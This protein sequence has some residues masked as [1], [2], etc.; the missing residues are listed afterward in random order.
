MASRT[1]TAPPSSDLSGVA[2]EVR[3]Q[4]ASANDAQVAS[5]VSQHH[6]S[7]LSN[8][9][10]PGQVEGEIAAEN[11]DGTGSGIANTSDIKPAS[12]AQN[13][14]GSTTSSGAPEDQPG[15]APEQTS[16]GPDLISHN[17]LTPNLDSKI[18][19]PDIQLAQ[20]V[21]L[22]AAPASQGE[23][24]SSTGEETQTPEV[25]LNDPP[26]VVVPI[27][28]QSTD[29]DAGF[30]FTVPPASFIDVDAGDTLT[31]SATLADG[32]PLPSWLSFDPAT[33]T[34]SGTPLNDDVGALSIRVTATDTAGA[35]AF[36]DFT[37]TV[38]NTNDAPTASVAI[39]NQSTDEDAGFNF[40]VPATSFSDVDV[41]DSLTLSA[42]L[43]DGSSLPSWLSFDPATQTFTGT[44]LNEDVG[45][46][47]VRVT[48]T[49]TAGAT[50]YQDFNVTIANTNDAPVAS[51]AIADQS[52]DEDAG[53]SF[54]VPPASFTDVDVGD[55]LT[56][57]ATL[58][59]GSALP[60]WLSFDPSTQTFTGTPLNEDVGGLN[61]RVTATDTSGASASQDFTVTV[62]NVNDAPVASVTIADQS[63]DE[64]AGFSFTLPASSFTDVDVGDSLT[65]AASLAD[66]SPL[67][68]WLSFDPA[69]QTFS[70]TPL[71]EDV[72][73]LSIRVIATDTA[74]ANASQD[75]T[76]TVNNTNDAPVITSSGAA[77]F[78]ENAT[79]TV[80]T[81]TATDVDVGTTLA[82]SISGA[83]AALFD[84]DATTGVVTFKSSPN[85]EAPADA[86][87]DNVY[88][89]TVGASDGIVTT[90]KDV[91]IS[92]S[93]VNE[94][95]T[96][97][98]G[99]AVSFAER[100]TGAVYT[101][102]ATD[103]DAGATLTYSLTGTDAARFNINATTGVITFK[104]TPNYEAPADAGKNNVYDV[105][106]RASDGTNITTKDV[107]ITVTNVNEAPVI[108]SAATASFAENG[109]GT[110][111]T[112]AAT[113]VDAGTT[114]TYSLAGTDASK[115][116]IDATTGAVTFKTS[117]NYEAP[118]DSGKNNVYNVTVRASDGAL[119]TSKAVAITVTNVGGED[120]V[121]TSA[122][123]AN[124]AENGAGTVY[125]AAAIPEAGKTLTYAISGADASLFDI[126]ATTG[127]VTFK[128]SPNYEAPADA[129][130]NNVYDL[131]ITASDGTNSATKAVAI[132]VTNVNEAP[133]ITSA[134]TASFAENASGAVYTVA[135]TDQDAGATLTYSLTGTD[136]ARFN[137]N[138]TTGEITFKSTP[139][140]EAPA[141]S[142]KN[143][144]YDVTVRASDGVNTTSKAVAISVANVNE[145][146]TITSAAT[147][148]F[149]ENGTGTVYTATATDPDAGTTLS[150]SISG[151]DATLFDINATTGVVTF[152]SA[153]NYEA[154]A[155]AGGNNVYNIAVGASDGTNTT[156]KAV[157]ITVTNVNEAPTITSG[158][159]ASFAENASGTVYTVAA[160]DQDAGATLTY[161]L[162]GTDAARFNINSSTGA[163]TFKS[164]PN[165]EAP[166]DAG[167]N[168]VYDVTV[169][170]SDGTNITSKA[171]AITVT[172][173][174]EA[175]T[176]TSAATASFAENGTGTVYT[177]AATDPDAGTTLTYSLTGADASLFNIDA[178]TGVV[179]F[180]SAPNYETPTDAGANN[181]YN[182][183]VGAS[184]G[185]VT[186]SKAVAVTV[187][188]DANEAPEFTSGGDASFAENASGTVYTAT[189]IPEAG[190]S[191][192]YS[193]TG[194]DA[195]LFNI[196]ATT[197]AVTFKSS[198]NYEAP[199]D[200]GGNNVYDVTVTASDGTLSSTK[201]VAITVSNV[202]EAPTITS[203]ATASFAENGSGTV[204]TAAASDPDAGATLTYSISGAD[205]SL[206]N[207]D[208]TTGVVT[209]KSSPNFEAPGDAGGNNVYDVKVT[210]SDGT[211]SSSKDVAITVV[212]ANDAP[213]ASAVIANQ[214]I[215]EDA[216]FSFAVPASSFAD[217]D[218]GD[219]LTL[220][221]T[222]ADG[223]PLPAW[224]SFNPAT[225]TFSGT[226]LNDDV[227]SLSIRVT[228]TDTSGASATQDFQ[229]T[230]NNTNDGPVASATI[231]GQSAN[232]DAGFSFS[233]APGS[234][235]DVDAGDSLTY[236]ASLA[237]G[238]PLPAWL[239]FNPA[240]QTFSG[241]P[242]NDDVGSLNVRVTATDTAG[243]SAAQ[244]FTVTVNNTNDGPV[245]SATIADQSINEDAGFSFAVPASSFTDVDVGDSLTLS[246]T[247]ADGSP[248][249]AW[250][251][252]NPATQTFSGTP[253]NDDVGAINIRVT[254]TDTSGASAT[255][256]FQV[257]VN[258]TNDAPVI[259]SSGAA[260][261]AENAA[262]TVYTAAATDV[263]AGE[264]LTYS[265]SGADAALFN[266]DATTG[267]V[268]F[269]SSPNYEAPGDA[270]GNNVYD[271]TVG[272]SDGTVTTT[273]DVAISV[274]NVNEGPVFTSATTASFAETASGAAY[275]AAATDPDA[276]AVLTY[277]ISGADAA[278]FDID[279]ATGAVTFKS[280][281]NYEAPGDAGGN[282]VYDVNVTVSDGTNTATQ[283]VAISVT[284]TDEAPIFT[285]GKAASFAEN[286]SGTV[287]TAAATDPD[288][289][290]TITYSIAGADAALFD[291]N[292]TTGAITFKSSPNYE[293]PGDAGGDNVY[294]VIV[295]ATDGVNVT[296][297]AVAITVTNV[298]EAPT[299]TSAAT[300]NFAENGSGTVYTAA[301]TDP[302]AGATLTYSISGADAALFNINATTG[303][304]TFKSSPNYEAP[305]D[306]GGNNIYDVNVTASDGANSA[307]KAVA[308]T[309]TN[310]NEAPTV[311]SA[312]TASFAENGTG[313]VYTA[314]ATDPDAGATLTYS[315]SG[316]DAALFDIDATTGAVTFK[317]SPNY[318][319]PGDTG[320]NNVYD[321]NVTASDGSLSSTKAVAITVTNVNEAPT[322][323]SAATANFAE[324]GSGTVYSAS[325]TDPDAGAS[326]TYSISG[327]DAS[328]FNINATTGAVTFK[329]SPNYEAPTDA[330]GNNVYD[331]KV[332]ASDG[333]LSSTKDVAISVTNVNEAPTL[334]SSAAASFAENGSGTV[335][336][337][338]ATDPDAG[339]TI[340]Y[341][342]SGTDAS[343]FNINATTGAVTFK[344]SPNY[345]APGDTGGNN[346]YDVNV[347]AS[348]GTNSTT[349][350]VAITVTNVNE[351][352]TVTSAATASFAENAAGTV[353]TAAATD[354]DAG[355]SLTYSISGADAA[356]FNINATTGVVTFKSSPDY[357]APGDAGG[358]N[359]Y[360]ITVG[361]SDGTITTTKDVAITVTNVNEGPTLTSAST[362]NFAE[363]A[364]GTVYTASA[365]DP[366]A[367][368][369]LTYSISGA[370]A[371]LFNINATTGAVTFKSSPNYEAPGDAGGN[372]V[373]DVNVTASDGTN[374]A[375]KAVAITVTDVNEGPTV[376]S[377]ATA[378]F[379]EN[380]S[381]TVYTAT[382]TDPDAGA[383][384]TYS[385]SGADAALFNI[386]ATTG[387]VTFK[388]SPNYEAPG[389][390]G[391]NNV[392]DVNVTASDGTNSATKAVAI[393]VTNVNE[394]PTI[395]SAAT[396]SFAENATGTVYTAAATDPDAGATLTYSLTG[397][398]ASLFN[399]NATTGVVTFKSA[400]NYEAPGDAGGNNVYNITVGA[401]DG[402]NTATKAVA[403][404]VTNVNEAPTVTSAA[405]ASFAENGTGTVYT[406]AATDPDAGTTLTYSLTGAD[407]SLFN[408][409]S[410]TG[411]VTF[412]SAPN[413][414]AP[415]DAGGNN[416]YDITVGAS[417]GTNSTTKDVA[418]TVTNVNEAPTG[419][420]V[421]G[422]LSVQETV[423]SGGNI[424]TAYDP[425]TVQPVVA[426]LTASDPEGDSV[427][428]SLVGA[429]AGLFTISGNDIKVASGAFFDY[430][431]TPSYD[432]T[433][434]ATDSGGQAFDQ[435]V[436]VNIANY[437]GTYT[438]TNGKNTANGTSEEDTISGGGGNDTLNGG[439]GN[440]LLEGGTGSDAL[441]GGNG[442]DT[443]TYANATAGVVLSFSA[444]DGN[445]IGSQYANLAAGGISGEASGDS[446]S[447][448]EAFIG[449]NFADTVGGGSTDMTFMLG[450]GNDIFDTNAA[451]NVADV[452]YGGDGNDTMWTGGG[453]DSLYGGAGND[454]LNGEAGIDTAF[455]S[456]AT[457][458][459]TVSLATGGAQN[460]GG[461]GTDTLNSIEN[462]YGSGFADTLTGSSGDNTLW[463]DAGNDTISGGAGNDTLWGGAGNDTLNG[464]TGADLFMIQAGL[465]ID[466]VTGGAGG[467]WID[468][469]ALVDS[470]GNSY[471]GAFPTDWTLMLTSGSITSTGSESLTLSNDSSGYIQHSDGTQVN[472]TEIEQIRW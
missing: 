146:P 39:A 56:Y 356:L 332:T 283:A 303:A 163:I 73:A 29:E 20:G 336:T 185:T 140:Y 11:L 380:A 95:P 38:A 66:G 384:L 264:T 148:S 412:K 195:A 302:D 309:V 315:I 325:A 219:S 91:A 25:D 3:R 428:Y 109:I 134:A 471:S 86:G 129:G 331:V 379:A 236:S 101:V 405:T 19:T 184:D 248:L 45:A 388:S 240:T 257:T 149:T 374:S 186:T 150:Y 414:E 70:G 249:P 153:P 288:A 47:S 1:A 238:S 337:A 84:I 392:Y 67:P 96:I 57:S 123:T 137:I 344:S 359:V 411:V 328:L 263:D 455:Y 401:S 117:P 268:T 26:V 391:G 16:T 188:N 282:N 74:G 222:L 274:T 312:A 327:T 24:F 65:Y 178:T 377:A 251:S 417:D 413:Y 260:S 160:T 197:G 104:S 64:D 147:K 273:K 419:I 281:P 119:T 209:F 246:A 143:N 168:N 204:Y 434:R 304:V 314:A 279:P 297:N 242:L 389:D 72:G 399:I 138:K 88:D 80:Y 382:A 346:V 449:S 285:S 299:V 14:T 247:L 102:A 241:T 193:L 52:T 365:T 35:T 22:A 296:T 385:I 308:I 255:Q 256:D 77:G 243:A 272:A 415:G 436:T 230:V 333:T 395:T 48:A 340:T 225:Q 458:G 345:E 177:A 403:V 435:V 189:A 443:V 110:V 424:G 170:A 10:L 169:R 215:N 162:T 213:T 71:N 31:L 357:E 127:A 353:Y 286:A 234:F 59:D 141:D 18:L 157:A 341:S 217:A 221:A 152:K 397:A 23:Q 310:V 53:F 203:A 294:D 90:T 350:A 151:A 206:F 32:S 179:T 191:L 319:A 114:L 429:P 426:T 106:V 295:S 12:N 182:I 418:I 124:F 156:T 421:T 115:F 145:A 120:P 422:P 408:I 448:I 316:A 324:N 433:V 364:T 358:D 55:S 44:P 196:N 198:P 348:D 226:P 214:S 211:L 83:D 130:G 280:A 439:D 437:A 416:V 460:T 373:Y 381:G 75:F 383:T 63:T 400:P 239:S 69:T 362:A 466:S 158:A 301:A 192:T 461:A 60:S 470:S 363:N 121:F 266:I 347:T 440:D 467:S 223:S 427:V 220:S 338:A 176:I 459:V 228:A 354:P 231:A 441:N 298:N 372:N 51:V 144:V 50:A 232:E 378:N 118:I 174:N 259:T 454:A 352:P 318:E 76:V 270:G 289:G 271:I 229:V 21:Q 210:A 113:D 167:A 166:T 326:L 159:A 183:T 82:Y 444:T 265:I 41:G 430:E 369:S 54:T 284:D 370:D 112:A 361:A 165:Y 139:N 396:A 94:A 349:K 355:A 313:T 155:D 452:V 339:A 252:F 250:L 371:A 451:Y 277:S 290:S 398:D 103:Q 108:T 175:P 122:G 323:T 366:D 269:K 253:L 135:A 4:L 468:A 87:G 457:S 261:F 171:V 78:A 446:F 456:E 161:S 93:N 46:L 450:G 267:V 463:G 322:I 17:G 81:A 442:Y 142:G 105:T 407:A 28:N 40:T 89:I 425:G 472:F 99:S 317:S 254:A 342:I 406:I 351:A 330:G 237:D 462:L 432:L 61:V 393:T 307:T 431:T 201:D 343:L 218:A 390:A 376:T 97:T 445:G 131:D 335:Y 410:T 36:Q 420:T 7:V 224:L 258:N 154:P 235:T 199:G 187:T 404:S 329:S 111:Y 292:A 100:A 465:G 200:A 453:D 205:A 62:A 133:V 275:T 300:A 6:Q 276:G 79:G 34:F 368:A 107:A 42:T 202:N 33:Q 291:I 2:E 305:G 164:S 423:V 278:L 116:N 208:A 8:I 43:A 190:K 125:T 447:G 207:I 68:S 320:A 30:S 212:N 27:A 9:M 438:G 262:G 85:Y 136:A 37:I 287:Y 181:V 360:N 180:K 409:N 367:G 245:A 216:G 15:F 49:D 321:I 464:G 386:N 311:T 172:N 126:N 132:S 58:A 233:V 13:G 244:D 394:A 128:S 387:A 334:T 293:A 194:A 98:S 92:V 173:V 5:E 469:I 306:A 402:T 375:T 227:G